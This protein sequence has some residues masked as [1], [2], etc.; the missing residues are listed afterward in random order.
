M[1]IVSGLRGMIFSAF[2]QAGYRSEYID[3]EYT[4]FWNDLVYNP[5]MAIETGI[6][7]ITFF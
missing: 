1:S 5:V 6:L 3:G 2:R 4:L 7:D